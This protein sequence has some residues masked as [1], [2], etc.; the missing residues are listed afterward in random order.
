MKFAFIA[1]R[2]ACFPVRMMCR[3][4]CVSASGFYAA[5]LRP[6]SAYAACSPPWPRRRTRRPQDV[7]SSP[8]VHAVLKAAGRHVGCKRVAT[9]MRGANITAR[10]TRRFV[11]TT[12]SKHDHRIAPDILV[13]GSKTRPRGAARRE[14]HHGL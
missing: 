3:H 2:R 14:A 4:F 7:Y 6:E 12:A 10:R 5:Q 9:L 1:A 11:R 8:R 13:S